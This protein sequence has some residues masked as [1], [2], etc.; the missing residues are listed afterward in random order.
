MPTAGS[1]PPI[2]EPYLTPTRAH[3]L[4]LLHPA[5]R[6]VLAVGAVAD[7][8]VVTLLRHPLERLDLVEDDPALLELLPAWYGRTIG[9]ALADPR[10]RLHPTDPLRVVARDGPWD[11]ILLLDGDPTTLRRGRTRTLEF[12]SACRNRT[13]PGGVI[14]IATGVGDTYLDGAAGRML[15]IEAA[16]LGATYPGVR[17]LPGEG[18]TLVGGVPPFGLATDPTTLTTRWRERGLDDPVMSPALIE[19]L[20]DPGRA[21]ATEAFLTNADAPVSTARR[22]VVVLAAAAAAE[23]RGG[24]GLAVLLGRLLALPIW[25][26][27]A[28]AITAVLVLLLRA[29][30]GAT[31]GTETAAVVGF[32][33]MAWW[34]LLLASWQATV[35]SVYAEI[36]ALTAAFMAGLV[37]GA[38][39]G[40]RLAD[41]VRALSPLLGLGALLSLLVASGLPLA[42]PRLAVPALLLA[43]GLLTGAAFPGT[44]RLCGAQLRRG[45]GRAFAAD[46]AGA[47]LAALG[48]GLI[49]LPWAGLGTTALATAV[50]GG[51]AAAALAVRRVG[52]TAD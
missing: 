3:L 29:R 30:L 24:A 39:L 14:A 33:S 4:M 48:I 42:Q 20:T 17:A 36:G 49:G 22:P 43:G 28:V 31:L 13:A 41:P 52:R 44:A 37:A 38:A 27:A 45:A 35:G 46:E 8:M 9:A 16:T 34:L 15:A 11:L 2:P 51:G 26:L 6:R 7:G 32:A 19:V 21:R 50:L 10:V 5:P 12:L 23:G 1:R 25:L 47:A 18:V 40:R